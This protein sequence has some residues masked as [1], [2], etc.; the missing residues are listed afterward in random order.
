MKIFAVSSLLICFV[1]AGAMVIW[2]E[3]SP[4]IKVADQHSFAVYSYQNLLEV[5]HHDASKLEETQVESQGAHASLVL[6]LLGMP[7]AVMGGL[8]LG[9]TV[10]RRQGFKNSNRRQR[11]QYIVVNQP[12]VEDFSATASKQSTRAT[13]RDKSKLASVHR[14]KTLQHCQR[15]FRSIALSTRRENQPR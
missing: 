8:A 9:L 10:R 2:Q 4:E 14:T 5:E 12:R 13:Q 6:W 15:R 11:V 7:L 1:A 3:T